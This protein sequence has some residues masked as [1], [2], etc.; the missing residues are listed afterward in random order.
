MN[1]VYKF[2]FVCSVLVYGNA[3]SQIFDE[4]IS[5]PRLKEQIRINN[6][7]FVIGWSYNISD[8]LLNLK[9]VKY[10]FERFDKFGNRVEEALYKHPEYSDYECT[11]DYN[12]RGLESKS[13]AYKTRTDKTIY[14]KWF[15]KYDEKANQVEKNPPKSYKNNEKWICKFDAKGN[16]IEEVSYDV[17]GNLNYVIN[18][19]YD[20]NSNPLDKTLL[21]A[22]GNQLE[23]WV[24]KYDESG[25]N[26]YAMQYNAD[27]VLL[28]KYS[29]KYNFRTDKVE[30][31]IED[32]NGRRL[33]YIKY[34]YQY[35][36]DGQ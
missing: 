32:G 22:Y 25:Y 9:G 29:Y 18:I 21:D 3:F 26:L 11:Y 23:K 16:K 8:S 28:K 13:I 7:K 27:N 17:D 4:Q 15:Y 35:F 6:I 2:I 31:V 12:E 1:K 5:S 24:Y 33:L 14:K 20:Y 36:K 34:L 30:E 19:T 10:S